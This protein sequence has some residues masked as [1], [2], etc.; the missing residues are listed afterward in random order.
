MQM[1]IKE[2][3]VQ[4][5]LDALN[6]IKDTRNR[7]Y[8]V[9]ESNDY[10]AVGSYR[11]QL[12]VIVGTEA[13]QSRDQVG[14]TYQFDVH[15]KLFEPHPPPPL[16]RK[17][18]RYDDVAAQVISAL[19]APG[20]LDGLAM[21]VIGAEEQTFLRSGLSKIA[22]PWVRLAIQYS[23]KRANPFETY[24]TTQAKKIENMPQVE[25]TQVLEVY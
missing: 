18:Y 8:T 24:D 16:A 5:I 3:I 7:I 25:R 4:R 6:G 20:L 11:A 9:R 19:E 12:I 23:R 14:Q 17:D 2:K 1:T 13:E 10:T 22:G 15:V 21:I